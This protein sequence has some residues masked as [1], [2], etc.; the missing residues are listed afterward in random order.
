M[1]RAAYFAGLLILFA[2]T[3]C[4]TANEGAEE[5]KH[6]E[7]PETEAVVLTEVQMS[8]AGVEVGSFDT[9][10]I[11]GYLRA[12]GHFNLPPENIAAVTAPMQG[13]VK[14]ANFLVGS[15]VKK[16]E[17]LAV[18]THPDYIK[19]QEEYLNALHRV[20]FLKEEFHRQKALDS[21][22]IAARKSLQQAKADY[23]SAR[24][25]KLSL[26]KQLEYIGINPERLSEG[27]MTA[28]ISLRAPFSGHIS[29]LN[30][31]KGQFVTPEQELYEMIDTDHMHLELNVYEK[32]IFKVKKGQTIRF[33]VPGQGKSDY[34][35]T[36]YLI[37]HSFDQESRTVRVHGHIDGRSPDGFM[38]GL[39][40]EAVIFTGEE[41][42][43][44]LPEEAIVL[45]EGKNYIFIRSR[46][47]EDDR[48][49]HESTH[50]EGTKFIPVE[51]STGIRQQ[52]M[53]EI[54]S[55]GNLGPGAAVVTAGAYDLFSEMKKGEGGHHH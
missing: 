15:Y 45:N 47:P 21:A 18:L 54:L 4:N 10:N 53:V 41:K 9:M 37:A 43:T 48:G 3:Q 5:H 51:V 26:A 22:N 30:V 24:T 36:V 20:A 1:K 17:V 27:K 19:M 50:A 40:V 34:R 16:G 2:T 7:S 35:G 12:N 44:A 25:R 11:S 52:G 23:R 39:Y 32:D 55:A 33:T 31:H 28:T 14:E 42:V 38:R 29:A 46:T 6:G 49:N 8:S 13:T